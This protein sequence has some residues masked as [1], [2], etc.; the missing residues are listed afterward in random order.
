[1]GLSQAGSVEGSRGPIVEDGGADAPA[2][3]Q[4]RLHGHGHAEVGVP[5]A[6]PELLM[7]CCHFHLGIQI[8]FINAQV[9]QGLRGWLPTRLFGQIV[10]PAFL[11]VSPIVCGTTLIPLS[12]T[13]LA[14]PEK[15]S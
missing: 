5:S 1:M 10:S 11:V 8:L 12:T 9:R 14:L 6:P 3:G 2:V 15:R 7:G 4:L 13:S